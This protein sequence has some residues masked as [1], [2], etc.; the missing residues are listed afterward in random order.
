MHRGSP[1]LRRL[2]GLAQMILEPADPINWARH[3][4]TEPLAIRP[5]GPAQ[6]NLLIFVTLGDNMDPVDIHVSQA[7]AAGIMDYIE[8]DPRY[9][10]N[11]N[12]WLIGNH[13]LEGWC[14]YD[15]HPPN[16]RGD[17]VI[18][19]PDALDRLVADDGL[20]GNGF[21]APKPEPG[22]ELRLTVST[23]AGQSG[24]RF[25]HMQPCGSHSFFITDPSNPFNVDA[26][27]SAQAGYWFRS[28]GTTILDHACLENS[29]C[30]LP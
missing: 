1:D 30:P 10:V 11:P 16:A 21:L 27:L 9:G 3:F 8:P 22:K 17:E 29:S 24:I 25:A 13:V 5:D 18:F 6:T 14:G 28:G 2:I 15:R 4:V 19:D 12:D 26:Y 7:R 20:D 23:A